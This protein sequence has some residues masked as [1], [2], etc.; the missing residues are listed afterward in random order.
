MKLAGSLAPFRVA[1]VDAAALSV[2]APLGAMPWL[3]STRAMKLAGS[4]APIAD[5]I[6]P[7]IA[8]KVI[9][10]ILETAI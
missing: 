10:S 3:C 7:I 5:A 1:S 8:T 4:L 2:S 6:P 9:L